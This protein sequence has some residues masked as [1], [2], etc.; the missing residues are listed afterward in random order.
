MVFRRAT[1]LATRGRY[2]QTPNLRCFF[3]LYPLR[4][5]PYLTAFAGAEKVTLR[6]ILCLSRGTSR[7]RQRTCKRGISCP[8]RPRATSVVALRFQPLPLAGLPLSR[9]TRRGRKDYSTAC[10]GRECYSTPCV[11]LCN[12]LRMGI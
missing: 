11:C 8:F 9:F 7:E 4:D 6:L 12:T 5:F 2:G 10:V 3:N 1:T